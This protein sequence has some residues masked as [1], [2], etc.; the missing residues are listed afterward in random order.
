MSWIIVMGGLIVLG[1]I[2]GVAY[3][4]QEIIAYKYERARARE[5]LE[6]QKEEWIKEHLK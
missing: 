4:A 2:W 1:L 5:N 6:L 3:H